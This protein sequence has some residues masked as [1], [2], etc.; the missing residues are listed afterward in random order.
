[1]DFVELG[2]VDK[3]DELPGRPVSLWLA[4]TPE[5]HHPSLSGDI[6]VDVAVYKDERGAV[7]ACSAVCTHMGCVV[8]WNSAERSWDS[9][10]HGSRFNYDGKV[11]QGPANEDLEPKRLEPE[12]D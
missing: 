10:C 2:D 11:V 3:G 8:H 5:T 9:P 12:A 6:S 1:M 7:S 4:A